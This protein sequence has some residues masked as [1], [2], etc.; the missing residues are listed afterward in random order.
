MMV[1]YRFGRLRTV[2]SLSDIRQEDGIESDEDDTSDNA[3]ED[4]GGG[5]GR[6][7]GSADGSSRAK[8]TAAS[9]SSGS[10]RGTSAGMPMPAEVE[11][12]VKR[13]IESA[14]GSRLA[15]VNFSTKNNFC[16]HGIQ[17]LLPPTAPQKA[18]C[19]GIA[20]V[21]S[22][23]GGNPSRCRSW[24]TIGYRFLGHDACGLNKPLH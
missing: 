2:F 10:S 1:H 8:S 5:S 3:G 11:A 21:L 23:A 19:V 6:G 7:S 13:E 16:V 22:F 24:C 4:G 9:G 14:T 12:A 15:Q 18:K 17:Q 20:C